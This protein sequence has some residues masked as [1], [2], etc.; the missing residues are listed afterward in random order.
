MTTMADLVAEVRSMLSGSM[1]DELTTLSE[2]YIAGSG[3]LNFQYAKRAMSAGATLSVGLNTF[4]VL[5]VASQGAQAVV[6]PSYDGGPDADAP[7]GSIVRVKPRFTNWAIFRELSQEFATMSSPTSGIYSAQWFASPVDW[8][9]GV[10]DLPD[11][12]GDPIRLIRSRAQISGTT[13]WQPINSAEWQP[14]QRA[15]K[16]ADIPD[17]A[18][19][20]EFT[21]AMPFGAPA[22][23]EDELSDLGLPPEAEDIPTLGAC[24]GL[25]LSGESRRAQ[26]YAQGDTRRAEEV[27]IGASTSISREFSRAYRSRLNDEAARLLSVYGYYSQVASMRDGR[28]VGSGTVGYL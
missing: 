2:P 16:T 6:L 9:Y 12:Y 7:L 26:P 17:G 19:L 5:E 22:S 11:I 15:V 8:S 28:T 20:V 3:L 18:S 13:E 1:G 23:L 25:S 10:Y 21:F 24:V 27:P 14:E 4:Y